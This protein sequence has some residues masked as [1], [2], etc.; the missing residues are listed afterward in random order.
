MDE[1]NPK[2]TRFR[3]DPVS[4]QNKTAELPPSPW[5]GLQQAFTAIIGQLELAKRRNFTVRVVFFE[6]GPQPYVQGELL[7]N[8]KIR[9]EFSSNV[10]LEPDLSREQIS[11]L[12]SLGWS[13]P[14]GV[15]PNYSKTFAFGYP[16][17]SI[18][19]YVLTSIRVVLNPPIGAWLDF[20]SS[21]LDLEVASSRALWHKLDA[22]GVVCLPGQNPGE[23]IEGIS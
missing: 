14:N 9:I 18:A 13:K 4:Y 7:D 8:G 23:T 5:L 1:A 19:I 3:K 21:E 17:Q 6:S 10:F 16:K 12:D 22:P 2:A 15:L 11:S 20:G